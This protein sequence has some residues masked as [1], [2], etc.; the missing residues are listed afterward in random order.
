M[1][2]QLHLIVLLFLFT[3]VVLNAQQP[4]F[5]QFNENPI[6]LNPAFTGNSYHLNIRGQYKTLWTGLE[7]P[8]STAVISTHSPIGISSSSI[9]IVVLHDVFGISNTNAVTLNYAY[10]FQTTFGRIV[11]GADVSATN[12]QQ[13]LTKTHLGMS[14][15]PA[16]AADFNA[17]YINA[18]FGAAWENEN[19]YFGI[20]M[21]GILN[22]SKTKEINDTITFIPAQLNINGAYKFILN[23]AWEMEPAMSFSYIDKLP[24]QMALLFSFEWE[25]TVGFLVGYR[26][27][28]VYSAGV[29]FH[30]MDNF[31]IGYN[32]DYYASTL[33]VLGGGHELV[34]GF[35]LNKPEGE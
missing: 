9:G 25:N 2:K 18:G 31:L 34:L 30:F 26:S 21:P 4:F 16:L 11:A 35:D 6:V 24:S 3:D 23:D 7:T 15:D 27:N 5:T 17:M 33:N 32:Y 22:P 19:G 13:Q 8:P 1:I 14:N 28:N 20:A 29:K 12:F 10:R